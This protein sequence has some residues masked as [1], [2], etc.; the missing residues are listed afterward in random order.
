M[1][2]TVDPGDTARLDLAEP[3]PEVGSLSS[4]DT[5]NLGPGYLS[6][7]P[8]FQAPELQVRRFAEGIIRFYRARTIL[9][10]GANEELSGLAWTY[11]QHV[12]P[13]QIPGV[14]RPAFFDLTY[15]M[16]VQS[17]ERE[18]DHAGFRRRVLDVALIIDGYLDDIFIRT[19]D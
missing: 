16:R 7:P 17:P 8:D 9:A 5:A 14:A 10:R 3:D 1:P 6:D 18:F 4:G 19:A 15:F 12:E 13:G 2:A 11:L